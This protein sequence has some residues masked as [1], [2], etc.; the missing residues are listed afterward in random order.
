MIAKKESE[1]EGYLAKR[2]IIKRVG[3][4]TKKRKII[5]QEG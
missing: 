4:I 5:N 3:M 2:M 1:K